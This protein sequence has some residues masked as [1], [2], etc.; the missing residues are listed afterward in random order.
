MNPQSI[1]KGDMI[2]P[3]LLPQQKTAV[4]STFVSF[5]YLQEAWLPHIKCHLCKK[6]PEFNSIAPL[7][8]AD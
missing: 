5:A 3:I 4:H 6:Y 1:E 7:L 8:T 2:P